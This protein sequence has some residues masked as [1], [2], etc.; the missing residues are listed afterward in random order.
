[1][2]SPKTSPA[3]PD[4]PGLAARVLFISAALTVF[5]GVVSGCGDS[6]SSPD[7]RQDVQPDTGLPDTSRDTSPEVVDFDTS[8]PDS[9]DTQDTAGSE[10]D[11]GDCRAFGCTCLG[12][13]DCDSGLCVEG[14]DG[15]VCSDACLS[16]C[17]SGF[18]CLAVPGVGPDGQSVCVPR[19][20]RLCRPCRANSDCESASD[21]YP[22]F[23]VANAQ[24]E[25][26]GSS[27]SF[28]ATS[29]AARPCPD[30]YTCQDVPVVSGGVARV[31]RPS[32]GV[33]ECRDGWAG[34]GLS[35]DCRVK[36]AFGSCPGTRSCG[37]SGLSA[38]TGAQAAPEQCDGLDND[39]D[40]QTDNL[41]VTPCYVTNAAG[42][43]E[44]R[45]VCGD[46]GAGV[47]GG[48]TPVCDGPV[49]LVESCN[50]EDDD[51]DGS[52]DEATCDDGLFC[53]TDSCAAPVCTNALQQGFCLIS[54]GGGGG[55][56][57]DGQFNPLNPCERCDAATST[58]AWTRAPNTCQIDG[59]CYPANAVNPQNACQVC[60][61]NV[62]AT[63]WTTATN[64][65]QIGGQC[66]AA[67][68]ANPN[69][70]CQICNPLIST[71]NWSQANNTCQIQGQC[72]AAG[73][74]RP[75]TQCQLCD[76]QRSAT[77][78]SMAGANVGCDDSNA[79]SAQSFCNGAGLCVGDT[80]R[81]G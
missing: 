2:R 36:N 22:A 44:G 1:M 43:C 49:P 57:A 37:E 53:T 45:L 32:D 77:G 19:H 21:P 30:G 16:E 6:T 48:N 72:Y 67:N 7:I 46:L 59:A 64:T 51:C 62:S 80:Y 34:L 5:V 26:A 20:A 12:N 3:R 41:P 56:F 55:C 11:T 39:C 60:Q 75:G 74:A 58:T 79:C 24:P 63:A 66:W 69:S 33:C 18:D 8:P 65:C 71:S 42:S 61:P 27:G 4:R 76:P 54:G 13:G 29:C 50:G 28:C 35:T 81:S 15:L 52:T 25:P 9:G 10:T 78:W 68:Q 14:P 38:C 70:P 17:P 23:C 31:C 47:G 40:G 73:V